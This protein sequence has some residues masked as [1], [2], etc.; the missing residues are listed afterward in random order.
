MN[1][2]ENLHRKNQLVTPCS[3]CKSNDPISLIGFDAHVILR[4]ESK[5]AVAPEGIRCQTLIGLHYVAVELH[6]LTLIGTASA[7]A[8]Y[9]IS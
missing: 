3:I 5:C 9:V 8:F 4:T 7:I 1:S 2:F 6:F